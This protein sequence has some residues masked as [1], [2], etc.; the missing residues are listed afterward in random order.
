MT[1]QSRNKNLGG[2]GGVGGPVRLAGNDGAVNSTT[3]LLRAKVAYLHE[4]D[5]TKS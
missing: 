3:Q 2:G 4:T 1:S 5:R